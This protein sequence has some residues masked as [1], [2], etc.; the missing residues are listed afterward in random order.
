LRN[1]GNLPKSGLRCGFQRADRS[2]HGGNAVGK[3]QSS[4]TAKAFTS[5]SD[6]LWDE[7]FTRIPR[8]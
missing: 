2:C 7:L 8:H 6:E 1:P 3:A 5:P 4:N